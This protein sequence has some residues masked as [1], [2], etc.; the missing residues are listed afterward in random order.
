[1]SIIS[2]FHT[3]TSFSEDSDAPMETM[4]R[5]AIDAG[6]SILCF[7]EH[8]DLDYPQGFGVFAVDMDSYLEEYKRLSRQ[9][10]GKIELRFGLE[11]G[12]QPHL[13]D[14]LGRIASQYPFDFLIASQHLING[15]DPY[16]QDFWNAHTEQEAYQLYFQQILLNL[17]TMKDY[18]TLG[19][20]DYIVRYAPGQ[21]RSY[22]WE[23]YTE[24][25]DAI[26]LHLIREG[27]CL[28]VNTAGLKYG[29]GHPNPE[30]D[31]LR[32]YR[33]LGGELITIGSDAHRP[34]HIAYA[35][36]TLQPLL[37]EL[38]FRYYTIFRQRRAEQIVL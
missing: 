37:K 20:L 30:E 15:K 25:I 1:M 31:V 38:G 19:H 32:R 10:Q 5:A 2:D 18:D 35:F 36:H 23:V 34:E 3:H 12:M 4:I 11:L 29:L 22:S 27:K 9:Y 17:K 13:A 8:L 26:L 14:R 33:Q 28:E 24:A 16:F 6:L 7:T 21:N